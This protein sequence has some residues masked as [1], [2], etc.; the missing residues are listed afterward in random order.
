MQFDKPRDGRQLEKAGIA[1]DALDNGF[2]SCP[3]PAAL[4]RICAR[5]GPGPVQNFWNGADRRH[6]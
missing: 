4:H 2:R 1:Y 3:D 5:L 6:T